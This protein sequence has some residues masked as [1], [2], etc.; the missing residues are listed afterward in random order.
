ML[1][2]LK[3]IGIKFLIGVILTLLVACFILFKVYS[4]NLN[5]QGT[6]E[7][8]NATLQQNVNH[9]E[10][11]TKI[12]D[13][14]VKDLVIDLKQSSHTTDR[15]RKEALSDYINRVESIGVTIPK[16]TAIDDTTSITGLVNRM[17][18]NYCRARPKDVRCDTIHFNK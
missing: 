7:Q 8:T 17:Y 10:Q 12:T 13:K 6:L 14:V 15:I 4:D 9:I 3:G 1:T 16:D 2:L 5:N 18:E 11:S